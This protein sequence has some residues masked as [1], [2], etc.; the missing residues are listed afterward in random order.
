MCIG[1]KVEDGQMFK[2][3][4]KRMR[5]IRSN[6]FIL[7]VKYFLHEGDVAGVVD[8]FGIGIIDTV[9]IA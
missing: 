4:I 6:S 8:T 9:S 2:R 3:G 1:K 5:M 7:A